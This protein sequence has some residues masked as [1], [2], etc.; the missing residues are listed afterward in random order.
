MTQELADKLIN[1]YEGV[2]RQAEGMDN[3]WEI[4]ELCCDT[5][6]TCGVCNCAT[7]V[8]DADVYEDAWVTS[9]G[10]FW[11]KYPTNCNTKPEIIEALQFR[12]DRLK[13]FKSA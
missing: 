1:H 12:I 9:F 6:T 13:T 4:L 3:L 7:R 11:F 5:Q 8:F 10:A 2:V